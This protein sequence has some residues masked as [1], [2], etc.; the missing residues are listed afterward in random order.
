MPR[1]THQ[2]SAAGRTLRRCCCVLQNPEK[3]NPPGAGLNDKADFKDEPAKQRK[4]GGY[5]WIGAQ[6]TSLLDYERCEVLLVAATT[7]LKGAAWTI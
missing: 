1:A 6:D 2:L 4:F 5:N 3:A 7:D